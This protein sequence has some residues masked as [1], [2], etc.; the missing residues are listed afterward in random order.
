MY[1]VAIYIVCCVVFGGS[2]LN[3]LANDSLDYKF[4]HALFGR[5]EENKLDGNR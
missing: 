4:L 2:S 1:I 3:M 5:I